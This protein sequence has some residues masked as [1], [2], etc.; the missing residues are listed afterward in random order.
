MIWSSLVFL[1][2]LLIISPLSLAIEDRKL[3]SLAQSP[4]WWRLLHYRHS[5]LFGKVRSD[6]DGSGFFLSPNGKT[7]PIAELKVDLVAF[8]KNNLYGKQN[9]TAQ[10]AFPER[11]RFIKTE[12]GLDILDQLCPKLDEFLNQFDAQSATLVFSSAYPHNPGSMFGHTFLRINK[13]SKVKNQKQDILDFGIS[14]AA[15]VGD[16]DNGFYFAWAGTTGGY[17]GKFSVLP[18]YVKVNEYSNSESRDIWEYDLNLNSEETNRLLRHIWELDNNSYFDYFF[19][20]EN[21]SFQILAL[22]EVA[23]P[24]WNLT[25]GF[26]H[27]IPAETVK[28]VVQSQGAVLNIKFRPSLRKK[29]FQLYDSLTDDEKGRFKDISQGMREP[30]AQDSASVLD[31]VVTF[32]TYEKQKN[33]GHLSEEGKS[34]L[35]SS[36]L[37]RSL[38]S[39][40]ESRRLVPISEMTR[41]DLSHHSNRL[42]L[43]AGFNEFHGGQGQSNRFEEL[44]FRF[45]YHDILN[46]DLGFTPFTAIEFPGL[47]LRYYSQEKSLELERLQLLSITNLSPLSLLEKHF[48]WKADLKLENPKDYSC[49]NCHVAHGDGALGLATNLVSE[50]NI[51]YILFGG[52]LEVS[53]SF[54]NG[55]RL[56]PQAEIAMILSPWIK[57]KLRMSSNVVWDLFQSDR[58]EKFYAFRVDQSYSFNQEWELRLESFYLLHSSVPSRDDSEFKI[59]L[60]KYF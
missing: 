45:A 36:L 32:E 54:K 26:F 58:Q 27:V 46:S 38:I 31:S 28:R 18:Y 37:R 60:N 42:A 7:D 16:N 12:L 29:M 2:F 20:D 53:E 15:V 34:I 41:P 11:Y 48:S 24:Q 1:F 6:L 39:N 55:Y 23:K 51:A 17:P 52:Q 22:L 4:T 10:C 3:E 57:Y 35:G 30:T 19:L 44:G 14:F 33:E 40:Q 43:G 13:K 9:L 47:V 59:I 8:G 5:L 50:A 49:L 56:G 25:S 21:C